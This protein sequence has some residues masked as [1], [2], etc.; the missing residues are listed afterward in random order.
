MFVQ[1]A[2]A[3]RLA[4]AGALVLM[5]AAVAA[6]DEVVPDPGPPVIELAHDTIRL[7]S[8]QELIDVTVR[9]TQ[10][11]DF[12]PASIEAH[13]GDVVRFTAGDNGSHAIVF[14]T[15][16]LADSVH[17]WLESTAQLRSPPLIETG[18]AWV[19]TL[20]DAPP[21]EYPF[22]CTT[23]NTSGRLTVAAR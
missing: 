15:P 9:R 14:D 18:A 7:D 23:H 11:G 12:E 19:I 20:D 8:G 2:P 5:A 22:R 16:A 17:A 6:C 13:V 10:A 1:R 3:R 4:R 21:G